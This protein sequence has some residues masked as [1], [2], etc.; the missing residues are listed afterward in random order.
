MVRWEFRRGGA[1]LGGHGLNVSSRQRLAR[2]G[3][4]ARFALST[5][6]TSG[7]GRAQTFFAGRCQMLGLICAQFHPEPANRRLFY[8]SGRDGVC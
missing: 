1:D 5:P 7:R 6:T 3:G 4:Q 8:G 2:D